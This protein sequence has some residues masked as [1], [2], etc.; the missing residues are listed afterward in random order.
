VA[1]F[2]VLT[3]VFVC[4]GRHNGMDTVELM[5]NYFTVNPTV[6][7]IKWTDAETVLSY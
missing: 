7:V 4:V 3:R 2:H 5:C 1:V 6:P